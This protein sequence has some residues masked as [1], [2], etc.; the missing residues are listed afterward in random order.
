MDEIQLGFQANEIGT[1]S[2]RSG[3]AMAMKLSGAEDSTIRLIGRWK[4][5]SFLKY[6]R[7]QIQQF[8]SNISSRMLD[9]EHFTHIPSFNSNSSPSK[10]RMAPSPK[11]QDKK[12]STLSLTQSKD[13]GD[14]IK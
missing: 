7:K 5:D 9:H 6:I 4:S 1:H 3:G 11:K 2:I 14:R 8:S 12:A 10:L 13:G